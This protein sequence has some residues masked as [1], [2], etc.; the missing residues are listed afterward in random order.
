MLNYHTKRM[1]VR[2]FRKRS[3]PWHATYNKFR[4]IN[5][6]DSGVIS[7]SKVMKLTS[8]TTF[9]FVFKNHIVVFMAIR[10]DIGN[11]KT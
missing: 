3:Y 5:I 6:A 11:I 10:I 9:L 8:L 1:S 7:Q 4:L 2:Y